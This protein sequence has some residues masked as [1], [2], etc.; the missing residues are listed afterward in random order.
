MAPKNGDVRYDGGWW[1]RL[2]PVDYVLA[3]AAAV[4]VFVL[5]PRHRAGRRGP[6]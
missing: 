1:K 4:A 3:D 6:S 5:W 2:E